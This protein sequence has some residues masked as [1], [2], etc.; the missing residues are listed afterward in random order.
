ITGISYNYLN[1]PTDITINKDSNDG[2]ITYIYDASG[3]KLSKTV[4]DNN[5]ATITTDY[6]NGFIYEGDVLQ[7]FSH[8]E[9]YIEPVK[10]SETEI[11]YSYI[12]QYADHLGNIR[13]S[14]KDGLSGLEI[15][16]ENNYYPFG[17]KHKGYNG[18]STSSNTALKYKFGGKEL[19]ES[20][21]LGTYDFGARNYDASLGRW[22]NLDPL[23]EQMRRHSPYNYAFDNP[24]Y[25]IDPDGMAPEDFLIWYK[26]ENGKNQSF[27]FNGSNSSDA[28][29]NEFVN[30]VIEAYD[31]NTGNGGGDA[32]KAAAE[33]SS[34]DYQVVES[35]KE[36]SSSRSKSVIYWNPNGGLKNEETGDV[37]SPATILEHESD[38]AVDRVKNSKTHKNNVSTMD[39]NFKNKEEKRVIN[40]NETKT[41]K[42]NGEINK[43]AKSSRKNHKGVS[44]HTKNST[45]TKVDEKKS[46]QLR[47][48]VVKFNNSWTSE[49]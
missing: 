35:D 16:E 49:W 3:V 10:I 19:D 47:N 9:G 1:L 40:G 37:L 27:R 20:L 30:S 13:L 31:Y 28:P 6:A 15:V 43:N 39:S 2:N 22:M 26:D 17:L 14:Y 45:S 36:S 4:I 42:A 29:D 23:A 18:L 11:E 21:G 46:I 12:Y 7:F 38:H 32:M 25:F 44:V 5:G 34:N 24:V 33:D 8:A 41:A 48:R